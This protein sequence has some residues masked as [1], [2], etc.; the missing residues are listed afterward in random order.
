MNIPV[1]T[2]NTN[3]LVIFLACTSR[4][5]RE[6]LGSVLRRMDRSPLVV[7]VEDANMLPSICRRFQP[8][9]VILNLERDGTISQ[10]ADALVDAQPQLSI[11]AIS[12]HGN[13][14]MVRAP[15]HDGDFWRGYNQLQLSQ[16]LEILLAET[17]KEATLESAPMARTRAERGFG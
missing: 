12:D 6:L 10:V 4:M 14:V 2:A 3:H 5:Q 9:W 8:D 13:G 7:D 16:M 17:G 1:T 15:D 11:L